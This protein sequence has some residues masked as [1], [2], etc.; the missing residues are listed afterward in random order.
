MT[1]RTDIL[2]L[3]LGL[4]TVGVGTAGLV[5]SANEYDLA[6]I[7]LRFMGPVVLAF[8]GVMLLAVALRT[9]RSQTAAV[10]EPVAPANEVGDQAGTAGS[11]GE[12]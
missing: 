1:H 6:N 5:V 7:D 4:L 12:W 3:F 10:A 9:H 2:S 8:L 11:D